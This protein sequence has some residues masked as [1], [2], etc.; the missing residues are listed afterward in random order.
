M[1]K[2]NIIDLFCGCGGFTQGFVQAG[3]NPILGVDMWKD[4]TTTYKHNFPNSEI[5]NEDVTNISTE[6]L[7]SAAKANITEVDGIIG[8]PPCQG[9]KIIGKYPKYGRHSRSQFE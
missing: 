9:G 3:Y 4:A 5:L 8:G 1:K 6:E 2:I 7:L